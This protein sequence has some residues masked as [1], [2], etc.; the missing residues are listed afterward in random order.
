MQNT[1]ARQERLE[2]LKR[3]IGAYDARTFAAHGSLDFDHGLQA[4]EELFRT[5]F[6]ECLGHGAGDHLAT[7][8][9]ALSCAGLA[10]EATGKSVLYAALNGERQETG[11]L[12]APGMRACGLAPEDLLHVTVRSEKELYWVAEEGLESAAIAALV[13]CAGGRE[14]LYDFTISRRLKLR[15]EK[16]SLPLFL[17]RS[18]RGGG[19]SAATARWRISRLPS[20]PDPLAV[21]RQPLLGR[22]RFRLH[23]ERGP[24]FRHQSWEFEYDATGGFRL[25]AALADGPADERAR[26]PGS[27][28][29]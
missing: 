26:S 20:A 21:P 27:R 1:Q 11:R 19:A 7:L 24:L 17:V 8:G 13:L 18:W 4:L 9:F 25:A 29:A 6:H 3:E 2:G 10:R 28:A 12:Y 5:G 16:S 23:L 14:K 22:T 15:V